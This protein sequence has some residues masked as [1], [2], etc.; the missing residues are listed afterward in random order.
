MASIT[1]NG[2]SGLDINSI[3]SQLMQ[4]E[5]QPIA[6]LNTKEVSFQSQLSALGTVKGALSSFQSTVAALMDIN[7][8]NGVKATSSGTDVATVTA[9]N[10]AD[11]GNF[12][13]DVLK[14][15][16]RQRLTSQA[17]QF[18]SGDQVLVPKGS[19]VA[20]A[21]LTFTFGKI[22]AAATDGFK[23]NASA[24]AKSVDIS[25]INGDGQITLSEVRDAI[26]KQSDLGVTASLVKD[27]DNSVRLVMTGANTGENY[28]FK[29][30]VETTDA[31]GA[32]V[33]SDLSKLAFDPNGGTTDANGNLVA[34]GFTILKDGFAQNAQA[35]VNGID[36]SSASNTLTDVVGGL[37]ITL[38]KTTTD[39][40]NKSTPI[41]INSQRDSGAIKS[42]LSAFVK[43]YNDVQTS[44]TSVAGYN[45]DT[46]AS[47]ILQ[48]DASV[49][50]VQNQLRSMLGEAFGG[51][52]QAIKTMS[53]LGIAF[54]SDGKLALDSTKLDKAVTENLDSV[55][56]FIGAYDK[57]KNPTK[58]PDSSQG[59]FGYKL[60][61]MLD[62]MLTKGGTLDSRTD[63]I[64]RSI[65]LLSEQ[66]D[67]MTAKLTETEARIRK[68]YVALDQTL[69]K[70][71]QTSNSLISQLAALSAN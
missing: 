2:G 23:P 46:K 18:T 65:K 9:S 32:T 45:A 29:V 5:Q 53:Q 16:Q 70:M 36:V 40:N 28:A 54:Q 67:A 13:L 58:A 6:K 39:T 43:A 38:L 21:K 42:A 47:G 19:D 31:G 27:S 8:L 34:N 22:D 59:S 11:L 63:G 10:T 57:T 17:G 68:Q 25:D 15:A 3:V 66:R 62:K 20:K 7:K 64:N 60:N 14:L 33:A 24:P 50:G 4:I 69:T 1:T 51:S 12:S 44:I 71:Q 61:D 41:Q 35:K 26:N 49:R 48:G 55:L 37:T 30:G 52:D 56:T